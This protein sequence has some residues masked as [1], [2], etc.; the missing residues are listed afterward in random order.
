MLVT[1]MFQYTKPAVHD[2]TWLSLLDQLPAIGK[3]Q[4]PTDNWCRPH[5][6]WHNSLAH[7]PLISHIEIYMG[8]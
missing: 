4:T 1:L 3:S 5:W 6:T 7:S 8:E 2:I